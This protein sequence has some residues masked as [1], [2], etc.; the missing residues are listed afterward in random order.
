M[1][2]IFSS[3]LVGV[4]LR[5]SS[6]CIVSYIWAP[7]SFKTALPNLKISSYKRKFVDSIKKLWKST[8]TKCLEAL[9]PIRSFAR[10]VICKTV[11]TV[12]LPENLCQNGKHSRKMLQNFDFI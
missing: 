8:Y 3:G 1:F 11:T 9:Y 10:I 2:I 6:S 4:V 5:T 7:G 12:L